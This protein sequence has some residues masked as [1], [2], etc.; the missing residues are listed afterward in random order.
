MWRST[1]AAEDFLAGKLL[2]KHR[3]VRCVHALPRFTV[4]QI[5]G[6]ADAYYAQHGAWPTVSSRHKG[7]PEGEKW[8]NIESN[9]RLGGRGLPGGSS[10]RQLLAERRGARNKQSLPKL[11]YSMIL[12]WAR[13]HRRRTGRWPDRKSGPVPESSAPGEL[14]RH[15][16]AALRVG[17]R[18][19]PGGVSLKRFID[20]E[21]KGSNHRQ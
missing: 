18:G 4:T 14:W 9:L 5:L 20:E 7:L 17:L 19:L 16:D 8:F 21:L 1:W 10:L 15:I 13:A 12:R 3:G 2:A 6:W 11:S